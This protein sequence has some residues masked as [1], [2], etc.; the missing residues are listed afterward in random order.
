[1]VLKKIVHRGTRFPPQCDEK[2]LIEPVCASPRRKEP[3]GGE[4]PCGWLGKLAKGWDGVSGAG[5]GQGAK[6]EEGTRNETHSLCSHLLVFVCLS[7][8][9]GPNERRIAGF[10]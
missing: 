10:F 9:A 7:G 2:S 4:G 3:R 1:M 6:G 5:P 8:K